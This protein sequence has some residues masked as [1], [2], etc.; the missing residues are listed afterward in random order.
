MGG[1][2]LHLLLQRPNQSAVQAQDVLDVA[3]ELLDQGIW[4]RVVVLAFHS[5][6]LQQNL[7]NT[8]ETGGIV[9]SST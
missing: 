1:S 2:S 3:E 8:E 6:L 4:E 9:A 7:S 5:C